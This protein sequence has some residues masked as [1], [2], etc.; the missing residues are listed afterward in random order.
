MRCWL[1]SAL[2]VTTKAQSME[3][4]KSHRRTRTH[5]F[6]LVRVRRAGSSGAATSTIVITTI[7]PR[8][9]AR[10]YYAHPRARVVSFSVA[11]MAA[12]GK[13]ECCAPSH[14]TEWNW[15]S[16]VVIDNTTTTELWFYKRGSSAASAREAAPRLHCCTFGYRHN[17]YLLK[18]GN[19]PWYFDHLGP[20]RGP[21]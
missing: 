17:K 12:G 3:Q 14:R 2:N 20:L 6:K 4:R 19:E 1:C 13:E 9:Y 11:P 8:I 21:E 16:V 10:T 15:I 7:F 5:Y 18:L